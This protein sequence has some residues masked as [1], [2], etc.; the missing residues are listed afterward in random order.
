LE[1]IINLF[2]HFHPL[3]VH[4]PIGILLFSILIHG[5]SYKERFASFVIIIPFTYLIGALAAILSCLSGLALSSQG[6]YD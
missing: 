3:L 1:R 2:G 4:L 5:L 6:E